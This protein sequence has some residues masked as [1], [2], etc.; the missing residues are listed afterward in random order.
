M[1]SQGWHAHY[2]TTT[3]AH[4]AQQA[5]HFT[6]THTW[7]CLPPSTSLVNDCIVSGGLPPLRASSCSGSC[8]EGRGS[9]NELS[10]VLRPNAC[11]RG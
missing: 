9:T 7:H 4:A 6:C 8:Q 2:A 11:K 5:R 3:M 10:M 1:R